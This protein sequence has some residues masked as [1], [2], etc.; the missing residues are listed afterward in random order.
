MTMQSD[1]ESSSFPTY[2]KTVRDLVWLDFGIT[3]T[4]MA[5]AEA[6]AS[7][8]VGETPTQCARVIGTTPRL[9]PG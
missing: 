8:E 2:L 9:R 6:H 5:K 4:F 3:L 1:F 7:Y